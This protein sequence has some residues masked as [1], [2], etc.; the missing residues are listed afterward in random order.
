MI[1]LD[2]SFWNAVD[3]WS[4]SRRKPLIV[5]EI[6]GMRCAPETIKGVIENFVPRVSISIRAEGGELRLVDLRGY[7]A[8]AAKVPQPTPESDL[9]K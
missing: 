8:L 3:I 2:D 1:P 4:R 7:R 6:V 9:Y 5:L